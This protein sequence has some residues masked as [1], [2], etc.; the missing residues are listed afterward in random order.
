MVADITATDVGSE[1]SGTTSHSVSLG[2]GTADKGIYITFDADP[3]TVTQPTDWTIE[4]TGNSGGSQVVYLWVMFRANTSDT[5]VTVTTSNSVLSAHVWRVF[6]GS[7][8]D[9]VTVPTFDT[10]ASG[11]APDPPDT[12]TLTSGDYLVDTVAGWGRNRSLNSY[13]TDYDEDQQSETTNTRP[14][15]AAA[16]DTLLSITSEDPGTYALSGNTEN[17]A[18]TIAIPEAVSAVARFIRAGLQSRQVIRKDDERLVSQDILGNRK[19]T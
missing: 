17:I 9:N 18:G 15:I 7:D 3:G 8:V 5:S 10:V 11:A 19:S 13:P 6:S 14:R 12:G 4:Q 16:A 2:S 1:S